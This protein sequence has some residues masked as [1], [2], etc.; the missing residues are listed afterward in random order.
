MLN[1]NEFETFRCK[2]IDVHLKKSSVAAKPLVGFGGELPKPPAAIDPN[3]KRDTR[4]GMN[5]GAN[6]KTMGRTYLHLTY[7]HLC[8]LDNLH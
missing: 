1:L 4:E 2:W 8:Y 6:F 5:H 7:L 3:L